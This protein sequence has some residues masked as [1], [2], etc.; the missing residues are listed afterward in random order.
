MNTVLQEVASEK[1]NHAYVSGRVDDWKR[2]IQQLYSDVESWLPPGFDAK[3]VRIV[4]M[5]EE[6]MREHGVAPV[7]LPVLG[8]LN[9]SRRAATL[10]PRGLWVIGA[11]GRLDLVSDDRH[12]IIVDKAENLKPTRWMVA[13][14]ADRTNLRPFT[15]DAL[16]AALSQ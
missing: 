11:N 3:P 13:P 2:R 9:G 10:E 6:L 14:L 15:A 1:L 5:H 7:D 12:F 4:R 8:I 16:R